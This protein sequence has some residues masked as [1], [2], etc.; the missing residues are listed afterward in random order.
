MG[1]IPYDFWGKDGKSSI[2]EW[3]IWTCHK[4]WGIMVYI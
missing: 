2:T 3:T 4:K 1:L